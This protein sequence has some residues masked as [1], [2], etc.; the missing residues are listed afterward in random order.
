MAIPLVLLTITGALPS[1]QGHHGV[2]DQDSPPPATAPVPP[3]SPPAATGVVPADRN[4]NNHY[5]NLLET[6]AQAT[7]TSYDLMTLG[8]VYDRFAPGFSRLF[9]DGAGSFAEGPDQRVGGYGDWTLLGSPDWTT[10]SAAAANGQFGFSSSVNPDGTY[11]GSAR[12]L[13]L[14]PEIDL[15]TDQVDPLLRA[16]KQPQLDAVRAVPCQRPTTIES[17]DPILCSQTQILHRPL[18]YSSIWTLLKQVE[19]VGCLYGFNTFNC[20]P[21]QARDPPIHLQFKARFN[22]ANLRDGVTV[23]VFTE[24][25]TEAPLSP[26]DNCDDLPRNQLTLVVIP[27]AYNVP[28]CSRVEP[29]ESYNPNNPTTQTIPS[30]L[31]VPSFTG[32][33]GWTNFTIDLTPWAESSIW[34]GFYFASGAIFSSSYFQSGLFADVGFHGL[35]LDDLR[36]KAGAPPVSLR[37]RSLL[38]PS[39]VPPGRSRPTIA[40]ERPIPV[41]AD[42]V[43]AGSTSA[44]VVVSATLSNRISGN[45]L[46]QQSLDPMV[47]PPGSNLHVRFLFEGLPSGT[48]ARAGVNVTRV[49]GIHPTDNPFGSQPVDADP[50]N[51][52]R[53]VDFDVI[54]FHSLVAG[55]VTRSAPT[56]ILGDNVRYE[57]PI[58]NFGNVPETVH[59]DARVV[60]ILENGSARRADDFLDADQLRQSA[61]IGAGSTR[62]MAWDIRGIRAG[63]FRLFLSTPGEAPFSE[64][65]DLSSK[66]LRPWRS[67]FVPMVNLA[68]DGIL[69]AEWNQAASYPIWPMLTDVDSYG[70]SFAPGLTTSRTRPGVVRVMNDADFVYFAITFN[71]FP[72]DTPDYHYLL[73][74]FDDLADARATHLGEDG[75]LIHPPPAPLT[76][77]T[78]QDLQ[79]NQA[80]V[81]FTPDAAN[82]G[83]IDG[84]IPGRNQDSGTG[85]G[86]YP[87][88]VT[89][90][91]ARPLRSTDLRATAGQEI[92]FALRMALF[93]ERL[94]GTTPHYLPRMWHYPQGAEMRDGGFNLTRAKWDLKTLNATWPS[95]QLLT[96]PNGFINDEMA[97]WRP[98]RLGASA[99]ESG[100]FS[101]RVLTTGFGVERSPPPVFIEPLERCPTS[102]GWGQV[103]PNTRVVARKNGDAASYVMTEKWNCAVLPG[104]DAPLLYE[105]LSPDNA[106]QCSVRPC[107][108]YSVLADT[109]S[110][111]RA[112]ELLTPP[113]DIPNVPNPYLVL[114][115]QFSTDTTICDARM[116]LPETSAFG[117]EF[118]ACSTHITTDGRGTLDLHALARVFVEVWDETTQEWR[119]EVQLVPET[120]D[121]RRTHPTEE[122]FGSVDPRYGQAGRRLWHRGSDPASEHGR[123]NFIGTDTND[124]RKDTC[125]FYWPTGWQSGYRNASASIPRGEAFAGSPW[126]VDRFPLVGDNGGGLLNYIDLRGKTVRF[127][128]QYFR[129]FDIPALAQHPQVRDFGWRIGTIAVAEGAQPGRDIAI[130]SVVPQAR[131]FDPVAVGLGPGTTVP[132][133]VEIRNLGQLAARRL[134]VTVWGRELSSSQVPAP[135]ICEAAAQLS[136]ILPP[137]ENRTATVGCNIPATASGVLRFDAFAIPEEGD[138]FTPDNAYRLRKL[139]PIRAHTDLRLHVDAN[140]RVASQETPRTLRVEIENLGNVPAEGSTVSLQ[141]R[142]RADARESEIVFTRS[143]TLDRA[144]PIGAR[145]SIT[146]SR[147]E[148]DPPIVPA[149]D[150]LFRPPVAGLFDVIVRVQHPAEEGDENNRAESILQAMALVYRDDFDNRPFADRGMVNGASGKTGTPGVWGIL[151]GGPS[152]NRLHAGNVSSGEFPAPDGGTDAY[153]SLPK[154][155]LTAARTATLTFDH[156][157]AFE[158]QFDAGRVELSTDGIDWQPLAPRPQPLGG[159]PSGYSSATLIGSSKML[160]DTTATTAAAFTGESESLAGAED[161]W[162]TSEFDLARHP[163]LRRNTTLDGF[164]QVGLN[165]NAGAQPFPV[166]GS[167]ELQFRHPSWTLAEPAAT[168]RGR[169]W[170]IQNNTREGPSPYTGTSAWWS[171]TPGAQSPTAPNV[172]TSLFRPITVPPAAAT[173]KTFASWWDWRSGWEDDPWGRAGTGGVFATLPTYPDF[174]ND[175]A[176]LTEELSAGTNPNVFDT[177]G[178]GWA[179]GL[180]IHLLRFRGPNTANPT[181]P[182]PAVSDAG[183]D[184]VADLWQNTFNEPTG[185]GSGLGDADADGLQ[186]RVEQNH[187]TQDRP[188]YQGRSGFDTDGDGQSDGREVA[189]GSDPQGKAVVSVAERDASGWT[190]REVELGGPRGAANGVMFVFISTATNPPQFNA[191]RQAN[192]GWYLDLLQAHQWTYN[193]LTRVR[194]NPQLL[195]TDDPEGLTLNP[196]TGTAGAWTRS[197]AQTGCS[198]Q[199]RHLWSLVSA[200]TDEAPGGWYVVNGTVP[201]LGTIPMWRFNST[202]ASEG[203]PS[204]ADSRLVTPVVD[205]AQIQGNSATLTFDHR[206]EFEAIYRTGT[207]GFISAADG[208]A[209]EYSVYEPATGR[210]GPWRQLA[211]QFRNFPAGLFVTSPSTTGFPDQLLNDAA[212][213]VGPGPHNLLK[214]PSTGYNA[215]QERGSLILGG[216]QGWGSTFELFP[217]LLQSRTPG[218]SHWADYNVSYVFSGAST[219]TNGWASTQWDL[220]PLIGKQVRFAFHSVTNPSYIFPPPTTPPALPTLRPL[221]GWSIANVAVKGEIF[222]GQPVHLRLRVATDE[223]LHRGEWNIDNLQIVAQRYQRNIALSGR[224]D[225]TLVTPGEN[226]VIHGN[227]TNLGTDSRTGMIL[228]LLA[229]RP[230]SGSAH[231]DFAVEFPM[232]AMNPLPEDEWP[233][234]VSASAFYGPFQLAR[235]GMRGSQIPFRVA[236]NLPGGD[237]GEVRVRAFILENQ[238]AEGQSIYA[239]PPNE[240]PGAT[241]AIWDLSAANVQALSLAEPLANRKG[242]LVPNVPLAQGEPIELLSKLV[243]TGTTQPQVRADWTI[244]EIR[245]KGQMGAPFLAPE[246]LGERRTASQVL[247]ILPRDGQMA[248][249]TTFTR[250]APGL[251]RATLRVMANDVQA[252]EERVEF[253]VDQDGKHYQV[254]FTS[255]QSLMGSSGWMD[256]SPPPNSGAQTGT[257]GSPASVAWRNENGRTLWGVSTAQYLA[258]VTYC[259]APGTVCN[260]APTTGNTP[261][262]NYRVFGMEGLLTSPL[263]NLSKLPQG[264]ATLTLQHGHGFEPEDG[265]LLEVIAYAT[266]FDP[267]VGLRPAFNCNGAPVVFMLVPLET[268][269]YQGRIQSQ[270]LVF[271]PPPPNGFGTGRTVPYRGNPLNRVLTPLPGIGGPFVE[272]ETIGFDLSQ[273]VTSACGTGTIQTKLEGYNVQL[274]LHLGTRP[275]SASVIGTDPREGA[276]GWQLDGLSITSTGVRI[277][278]KQHLLPIIDGAQKTV[279]LTV[280]NTGAVQDEITLSTDPEQSTLPK[281]EWVKLPAAKIRLEPGERRLVPMRVIIPPDPSLSRSDY[282]VRVIAVSSIDPGIRDATDLT[283][284]LRPN[285]LPDLQVQLRL[286]GDSSIPAFEQGTV[287]PIHALVA[288]VGQAES[289]ET[290]LVFMVTEMATGRSNVLNVR[291][292]P[293]LCPMQQCGNTPA[294]VAATTIEWTVPSDVGLYELTAVVDPDEHLL[295]ERRSNNIVIQVTRSVPLQRPDLEV[296]AVEVEGASAIG[297]VEEGALVSVRA[298]VRNRGLTPARDANWRI[299]AGSAA[300]SEGVIRTLGPGNSVNVTAVLAASAGELLLRAIVDPASEE[301]DV[302]NNER[303]RLL[304]V[305]GHD[306]ALMADPVLATVE[307]GGVTMVLIAVHNRGNAVDQVRLRADVPADL[308]AAISP[309]PVQIPPGGTAYASLELAAGTNALAGRHRILVEGLPSG[310]TLAGANVSLLLE[311]SPRAEAPRLEALNGRLTPG[312]SNVSAVLRGQANHE[313]QGRLVLVRPAWAHTP[314]L[315]TLPPQK[316]VTAQLA[317][318]VPRQEAPGVRDL[319]IRL[320][321]D[322]GEVMGTWDARLD[323]LPRPSLDHRWVRATPLNATTLGEEQVEYILALE[324]TGN[325][326]LSVELR[327]RRNSAAERTAANPGSM[328]LAPGQRATVP[329]RSPLGLQ[330]GA[331]EVVEVVAK[332]AGTGA[333]LVSGL[334]LPRI[335]DA[336]NLVVETVTAPKKQIRVG[337]TVPVRIR[338]ANHGNATSEPARLGAY[339]NGLLVAEPRLPALAK[340][341]SIEIEVN[342]V[343]RIEGRLLVTVIADDGSDV[344]EQ[345][346]GDNGRS[347][348]IQV[349]AQA[350][351][352]RFGGALRQYSIGGVAIA[353]ALVVAA[354][355]YLRMRRA[356]V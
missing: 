282:S 70:S 274:R 123:C 76:P 320:V 43:N 185:T 355:L 310:N 27:Q 98:I 176:T 347:A 6:Y 88:D 280:E 17:V 95:T 104:E 32:V 124:L 224:P 101:A 37:V 2:P 255:A 319:R 81:G 227:V 20:L 246:E 327:P 35:H 205:L 257:R 342:V 26:R 298:E 83:T 188:T 51:D 170:W 10:A 52:A 150:L 19:A 329:V 345:S 317:L 24:R 235:V 157:F 74:A 109:S 343:A 82:G 301:T 201:G 336:P 299:L 131:R 206:F 230:D 308:S 244:D 193:S 305:R 267:R 90:E 216:P 18:T 126:R 56:I 242:K 353:A 164:S 121:G 338:V 14:S 149:A 326:A 221:H 55:E 272:R 240:V 269:D 179:D 120:P 67:P 181:G 294:A 332:A 291:R 50:S 322:D 183:G 228:G 38:E 34:V 54:D 147:L 313:Q 41:E 166:P 279:M 173:S 110:S 198:T 289:P 307:P 175:G 262:L 113:I 140:P 239:P 79:W 220:S 318:E 118:Q 105:G 77:P 48:L 136:G 177:D 225:A 288:N 152:G 58:T 92:S 341:D 314:A 328:E 160:Q 211:Q 142:R 200:A 45:T 275:G 350:W 330:E 335:Q 117:L 146:D 233:N 96:P 219:G 204:R 296:V 337:D 247:G 251:Y 214:I 218:A 49:A 134:R 253:F 33:A 348:G 162:L 195:L 196:G 39:L 61:T 119:D 283:V 304:R 192:R 138:D 156:N 281:T 315:V 86:T 36:V 148:A 106:T 270:P 93:D 15:R 40:P 199:G 3:S 208:G 139:Y 78:W 207:N 133:E 238:D 66:L 42:V 209:V 284:R 143:W 167:T 155:D 16:T 258:G 278:P 331:I 116:T 102:E 161:G 273:T 107:D 144:V 285:P 8:P 125:G 135:I 186:R 30:E 9:K 5:Q 243:N 232:S 75:I 250:P 132:V 22:L 112:G 137:G 191:F 57:L 259:R 223:S 47:L 265:A 46:A 87:L 286:P 100:D 271:Q 97:A 231:D 352:D 333:P 248:L 130:E 72:I 151:G 158:E 7:T 171:G 264:L 237:G 44:T 65:K 4:L 154:L 168:A 302:E 103:N 226:L 339:T 64:E 122:D 159:L 261:N 203:Y 268:N 163:A 108:P 174:D 236:V 346:E 212:T 12:S 128:F 23:M 316:N 354:G 73:V 340:G 29:L 153:Y 91:F 111:R 114:H 11:G 263:V 245:R 178:D 217:G 260:F 194:S 31:G 323:V 241:I 293:S 351:S 127:H 94:D 187:W 295:E 256:E 229:T 297:E 99:I 202:T 129:A 21:S 311:V 80:S 182:T 141:I 13:L 165:P 85:Y 189:W 292:V 254:D 89:Y 303:S 210:F 356:R 115:H 234:E 277:G 63:Q 266:P 184:G 213:H 324:N 222:V 349:N 276:I 60:E 252:V 169:Y 215:F 145:T 306:L 28:S 309:N 172:C 312:R 71:G 325:V 84:P 287:S 53:T 190:R 344:L 25:P 59:I 68:Y 1:I 321:G 334:L 69:E 290:D 197:L 180:E 300:L 249:Q 62:T